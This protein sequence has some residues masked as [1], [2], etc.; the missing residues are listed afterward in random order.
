MVIK[1]NVRQICKR[2]ITNAD[3]PSVCIANLLVQL[4]TRQCY[5]SRH[6]LPIE[7]PICMHMLKRYIAQKLLKTSE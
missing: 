4:L 3:A 2:S 7:D 6:S 1:L 5:V